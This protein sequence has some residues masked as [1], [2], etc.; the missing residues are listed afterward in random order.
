MELFFLCF[1]HWVMFWTLVDYSV[2]KLS[3]SIIIYYYTVLFLENRACLMILKAWEIKLCQMRIL[4][5]NGKGRQH[6]K[7]SLGQISVLPEC[8]LHASSESY[9]RALVRLALFLRLVAL[10]TSKHYSC[11]SMIVSFTLFF[12]TEISLLPQQCWL[13]LTNYI[14]MVNF[15]SFYNLA[16]ELIMKLL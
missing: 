6:R 15:S 13:V 4:T 3:H 9:S 8:R 12:L 7:A 2:P 5:T 14:Y 16:V 10:Y 11:H 1:Q